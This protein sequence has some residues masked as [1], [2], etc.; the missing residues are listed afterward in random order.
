MI[1]EVVSHTSL[2]RLAETIARGI[3]TDIIAAIIRLIRI[4]IRYWMN[5]CRLPIS[6]PPASMR[7]PPNHMI[8]MFDRFMMNIISGIIRLIRRP[9]PTMVW[10]SWE[11]PFSKRSASVASRV[12]ARITRTPVICSRTMR[13]RLSSRSCNWPNSGRMRPISSMAT[14]KI[15]GMMTTSSQVSVASCLM[16][17]MM[18]PRN[19]IGACRMTAKPW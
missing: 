6:M 10:R 1:D 19:M 16:A 3:I 14:M 7:L 8:E 18:P 2:M 11:L 15:T 5:A 17:R 13:L 12:N 9:T 4:I